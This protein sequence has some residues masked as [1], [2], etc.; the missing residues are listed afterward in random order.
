MAEEVVFRKLL[1]FLEEDMPFWD[2]T[3][4]LLIPDDTMVRA[5]IIAKQACVAACVED[6]SYF[7]KRMG[8]EVRQFAKDGDNVE[9]GAAL[10]EIVGPARIIL[11][12][13]RLILNILMHCSGIATEVRR[14][15]ELVRGVNGKVRVAATRKT[16]PGLRYFEKKAVLI[17]GGDS[18]R[19]SLS[20]AVL[21]KDNHIRIIGDIAKAVKL[22]KEKASFAHKIE[23][24][25]ST[26]DEAIK[27][28]ESGADIVMLDNMRPDEVAKV[29]EELKNRGLRE[30]V[31]I[32]VSGGITPHNILDY[33]RLDVDIISCGYI[34]MSS[35]AVDMSLEVVEVAKR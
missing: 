31:L 18:H 4:D 29:I 32:E 30:R 26:V 5:R 12:V 17:G 13:E 14:L 8:L 25:A 20:D 2:I 34:T 19:F 6:I 28:A 22:A 3:T 33:A 16:L 9:K 35:K 27:A 24:E 11:G 1:R 21:I 10:L 15:V 7:L 23:I